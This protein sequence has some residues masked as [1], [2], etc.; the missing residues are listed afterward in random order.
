MKTGW[1]NPKAPYNAILRYIKER[2][3][4]VY[5]REIKTG[6]GGLFDCRQTIITIHKDY[7]ETWEGCVLLAHEYQHHMDHREG[8]F[9]EFFER[10]LKEEDLNLIIEAE[11]SA[12][13]GSV[14]FL[15]MWGINHDA[16][17]LTPEG[18]EKSL[19]FWR[20]YYFT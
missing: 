19:K 11:M 12:I 3:V 2:G 14:R 16:P 13:K 10:R 6:A 17:E 15:K 20:K 7:R 1:L 9:K 8:K 4:R 5:H 18:Y